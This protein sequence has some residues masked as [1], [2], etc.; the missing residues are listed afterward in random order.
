VVRWR[1]RGAVQIRYRSARASCSAHPSRVHARKGPA[2]VLIRI[3]AGGGG[4]NGIWMSD[5]IRGGVNSEGR[6]GQ[7]R[8]RIID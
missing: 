6:V 4:S 3:W 1:V 8:Y 5:V 7:A 2:V